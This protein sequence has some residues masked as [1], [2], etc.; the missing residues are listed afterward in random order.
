MHYID[1]VEAGG[2]MVARLVAPIPRELRRVEGSTVY[3]PALDVM[4]DEVGSRERSLVITSVS[5]PSV[6]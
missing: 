3:D 4:N 2:K 5:T 6:F 1:H